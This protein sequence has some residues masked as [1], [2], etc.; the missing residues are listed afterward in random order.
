M[1]QMRV[2][3]RVGNIWGE[4]RQAAIDSCLKIKF[5]PINHIW[6]SQKSKYYTTLNNT[7]MTY[8]SILTPIHRFSMLDKINPFILK[9]YKSYLFKM[10]VNPSYKNFFWWQ[11]TKIIKRFTFMQQTKEARHMNQI[12]LVKE[13]NLKNKNI[14]W[15]KSHKIYSNNLPQ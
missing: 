15:Y 7:T 8:I 14:F 12:D 6:S 9:I 13:T 4:V 5:N 3:D 1:K 11:T 10:I 2:D